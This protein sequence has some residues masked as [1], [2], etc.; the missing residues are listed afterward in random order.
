MISWYGRFDGH[1]HYHMYWKCTESTLV[2]N[3]NIIECLIV[4]V[5][6][7]HSNSEKCFATNLIWPKKVFPAKNIF[8]IGKM[9][10]Y[11]YYMFQLQLGPNFNQWKYWDSRKMYSNWHPGIFSASHR[12]LFKSD[13]RCQL[14]YQTVY[15][16]WT[17]VWTCFCHTH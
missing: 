11:T 7:V 5:F 9:L 14:K 15:K 3:L 2:M 4:W 17:C 13:L 16:S 6:W 10:E 12:L 1:Y 8:N